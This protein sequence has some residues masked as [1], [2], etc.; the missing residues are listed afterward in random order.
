MASGDR[1]A[2]DGVRPLFD[3]FASNVFYLGASGAA[4]SRS[5]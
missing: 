1:A 5:S 4:R 3:A 2:Y